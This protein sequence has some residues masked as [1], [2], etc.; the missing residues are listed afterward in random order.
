MCYWRSVEKNLQKEQY[1]VGTWNVRYMNQDRFEVVKDEM[2]I[3]N[4]DI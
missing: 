1:C 2:A 3:V 4:V